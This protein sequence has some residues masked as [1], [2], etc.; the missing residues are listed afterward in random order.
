MIV[1]KIGVSFANNVTENKNPIKKIE[2]NHLARFDLLKK[3]VINAR[4]RDITIVIEVVI[5]KKSTL[6]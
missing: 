6:S 4:S 3:K 2:L 5:I 1:G